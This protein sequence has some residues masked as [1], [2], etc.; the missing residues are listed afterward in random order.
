MSSTNVENVQPCLEQDSDSKNKFLQLCLGASD[1]AD[2]VELGFQEFEGFYGEDE[3]IDG[4]EEVSKKG[5]SEEGAAV[6]TM[7]MDDSDEEEEWNSDNED[8]DLDDAYNFDP[9]MVA[10]LLKKNAGCSMSEL[11]EKFQEAMAQALERRLNGKGWTPTKQSEFS[12]DNPYT[13][14]DCTGDLDGLMTPPEEPAPVVDAATVAEKLESARKEAI[15]RSRARR[16]SVVKKDA[17]ADAMAKAVSRH[18]RSIVSKAS[19]LM[20]STATKG[21]TSAEDMQA[22][23]QNAM[24]GAK[25]RHRLSICKAAETLDIAGIDGSSQSS[26]EVNNK[27]GLVQ[28]AMEAA[29]ARHRRSIAEAVSNVTQSSSELSS[30]AAEFK[31]KPAL[32]ADAESFTPPSIQAQIQGTIA[33]AYQRQHGVDCSSY[34]QND[35]YYSDH[36]GNYGQTLTYEG[37]QGTGHSHHSQSN[38]CYSDHQGNYDCNYGQSEPW[39][40]QSCY[41][42]CNSTQQ[43]PQN[44][45]QET[46][47]SQNWQ[48]HS[49]QAD[50]AHNSYGTEAAAYQCSQSY[51]TC[52]EASY[53]NGYASNCQ[54]SAYHTN[55]DCSGNASQ[56]AS[57]HSGNTCYSNHYQQ[58]QQAPNQTSYPECGSYSQNGYDAYG[59][60]Q[61]WGTECGVQYQDGNGAA[62][63]QWRAAWGAA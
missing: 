21:S 2:Q 15:A 60:S 16:S 39:V 34:S 61:N 43:E 36:Q 31:P 20:D 1:D 46:Q 62:P 22:Q 42:Q 54:Q 45:W 56:G 48:S 24:Q 52:Q 10:E 13:R 14:P 4:C 44:S 28:Q 32:S 38:Q 53:Q 35:Q 50:A 19:S 49:C 30:S 41:D 63:G 55:Y 27:L 12:I 5:S 47:G 51:N 3:E 7:A 23:I 9:E 8:D 18:R 17:I 37:A 6:F 33:S 29:R 40:D 59:G 57:Y 26:S 58:Q 11:T 25:K